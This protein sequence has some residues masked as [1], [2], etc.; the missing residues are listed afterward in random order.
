[1]E[2]KARHRQALRSLKFLPPRLYTSRLCD[3]SPE[4]RLALAPQREGLSA[5]IQ[6]IW[7]R[8]SGLGRCGVCVAAAA[9]VVFSLNQH[10]D[11]VNGPTYWRW[12]WQG[13]R[14]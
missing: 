14:A 3:S 11:G 9:A 6:G 7:K 2:C 13:L 4:M 8:H 12:S 10:I 5:R 1:M